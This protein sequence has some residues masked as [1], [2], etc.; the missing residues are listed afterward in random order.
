[1]L[2]AFFCAIALLTLALAGPVDAQEPATSPSIKLLGTDCDIVLGR[3]K[4]RQPTNC[5]EQALLAAIETWIAAEFNLPAIR[6]HPRLKLV[7]SAKIAALR[8]KVLL[9]NPKTGIAAN[10]HGTSPAQGDTVALYHDA[11]QSIYLPEGWSGSTPAELSVLVHEMVHHF[12]NVLGLKH[13]CPQEREKL[14]YIA[15]DRW[16]SL[17]GQSLSGDFALDPFSL[18]IKIAC[19]H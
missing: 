6:E 9:S 18:F 16:L 2:K 11:T 15:Q 19:F 10:D 1:M 7:S 14:A 3:A 5:S 13:E 8:F 17:F 4:F 12:Q